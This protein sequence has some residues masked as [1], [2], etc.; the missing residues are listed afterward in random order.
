MIKSLL[1]RFLKP[2]GL[3]QVTAPRLP[4]GVRIYAFGDVH[5]R[6]DLLD[7][8]CLAGASHAC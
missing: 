8:R 2:S 1:N 3:E 5:G 4:D 7:K 6:V